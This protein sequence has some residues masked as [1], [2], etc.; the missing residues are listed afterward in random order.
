VGRVGSSSAHQIDRVRVL[1]GSC[2]AIVNASVSR[3]GCCSKGLRVLS[4]SCRAIVNASVSRLGCHSKGLCEAKR[5]S[6]VTE[7]ERDEMPRLL[8]NAKIKA[9]N[10]QGPTDLAQALLVGEHS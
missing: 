4:G 10:A 7:A 3:L 6:K 2:R 5:S 1:S 9:P 8:L